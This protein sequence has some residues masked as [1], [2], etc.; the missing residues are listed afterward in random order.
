[1]NFENFSNE[2]NHHSFQ[3]K[4]VI[5]FVIEVLLIGSL[6]IYFI[7][8][9][10]QDLKKELDKNGIQEYMINHGYEM[11]NIEELDSNI[12]TYYFASNSEKNIGIHYIVVQKDASNFFEHIQRELESYVNGTYFKKWVSIFDYR[13]YEI[14]TNTQYYVLAKK[15]NTILSVIGNPQSK[16]KIDEIISDLKFSYPKNVYFVFGFIGIGILILVVM[17]LWRI[18]VKAGKKGWLALIPLYNYYC[19]IKLTFNKGWYIIFLI[20]P[21][22]N[23]IFIL[24]SWYYLARRFGKSKCFAICSMI[25]PY[26]TMQIIAFD[27][28]MYIE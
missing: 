20:I 27:N 28:S 25:F 9:Y 15:E 22:V 4:I 24:L 11:N 26:I 3:N 14:E 2:D 6:F 16:N 7:T 17:V 8:N 21:F 10:N 12:I 18:F 5:L 23:F 1:M 19:L 13:Y